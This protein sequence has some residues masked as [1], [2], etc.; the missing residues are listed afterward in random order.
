MSQS[1]PS[2]TASTP[3]VQPPAWAVLERKLIDVMNESVHPF[4][5]KYTHPDGELIWGDTW[6]NS[7]DGRDDR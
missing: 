5:D 4:L 2:V 3:L 6:K 7:R 1:Y